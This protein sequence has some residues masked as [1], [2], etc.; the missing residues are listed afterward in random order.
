M[1]EGV[2]DSAEVRA[3]IVRR[4][5]AGESLVAIC[6]GADMPHS[7]TVEKWMAGDAAFR[8]AVEAARRAAGRGRFGRVSSY[9]QETAEAVFLRL[10]DGEALVR[11]CDDPTMPTTSTLY[12]WMKRQPEFREAVL[13]AYE[14][15]AARLAE[16]GWQAA[17]AA[18]PE[19]AYL[20]RVRLEHLRWYA[21]K[22]GPRQ[23]GARKAAE[24]PETPGAGAG[25]AAAD[26]AEAAADGR[27]VTNVYMKTWIIDPETQDTR[28]SDTPA[29]LIYS[30]QAGERRGD[31]PLVTLGPASYEAQRP[32]RELGQKAYGEACRAAMAAGV[33]FTGAVPSRFWPQWH[34]DHDPEHWRQMVASHRASAIYRIKAM[35]S[36]AAAPMAQDLLELGWTA[37]EAAERYP[38]AA[39]EGEGG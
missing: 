2:R 29:E 16:A 23:F 3:E 20:T 22:L 17:L 11:I 4:C 30:A 6:S 7:R 14:I 5:A 34:R 13:L 32:E 26:G 9:C 15:C 10:W 25:E 31:P 37:E 39:G 1:D 24:A 33:T 8:A 28:P 12:A 19:T 27:K 21:S 36:H 35:A 18:T 38:L